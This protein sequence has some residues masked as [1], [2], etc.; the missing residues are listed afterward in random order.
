[1]YKHVDGNILW[2]I[3][4][5]LKSQ[6]LFSSLCTFSRREQQNKCFQKLVRVYETDPT[7]TKKITEYMHNVQEHGQPPKEII[8]L[9]SPGIELNDD[10][11]PDLF[12]G[13]MSTIP[14]F[15]QMKDEDC[16]IM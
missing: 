5:P 11:I 9:I 10:G 16:T 13:D 7:D 8:Q 4:F 6:F 12:G 2:C 14:P 1:V 3:L 15:G